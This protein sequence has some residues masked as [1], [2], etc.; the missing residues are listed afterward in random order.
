MFSH[1]KQEEPCE[2]LMLRMEVFT[3][4]HKVQH[5]LQLFLIL[6]E[7][8]CDWEQVAGWEAGGFQWGNKT[9]GYSPVIPL[10][11]DLSNQVSETSYT[12]VVH[13]FFNGGFFINTLWNAE[14]SQ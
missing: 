12:S 11:F 2:N 7:F 4:I 1:L 6:W 3:V 10:W 13:Y 9:S 8:S 14:C 5:F